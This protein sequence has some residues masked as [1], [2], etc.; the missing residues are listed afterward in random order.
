[1]NVACSGQV[2][3]IDIKQQ[4]SLHRCS[5]CNLFK[6]AMN[7]EPIEHFLAALLLLTECLCWI[8]NELAGHHETTTQLL[9]IQV[10][11]PVQLLTRSLL[12]EEAKILRALGN[13]YKQIAIAQQISSSTAWHYVNG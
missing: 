10:F 11:Q 8:I 3:Y 4:H 6:S 12:I 5:A 9:A 13:T 7:T 1:M 2:G